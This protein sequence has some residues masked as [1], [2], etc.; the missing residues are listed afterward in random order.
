MEAVPGVERCVFAFDDAGESEESRYVVPV[1]SS[2]HLYA[3]AI[4]DV[5]DRA[6]FS[7]FETAIHNFANT[8]AMRLE[9]LEYQSRLEKRV[10]EQ[11]RA[12]EENRA[13]LESIF[14][15]TG[16]ATA[17]IDREYTVVRAN[18]EASKLLPPAEID[19]SAGAAGLVG[20]RCYALFYGR[21]EP[22]EECPFLAAAESD[23]V[24][25]WIVPYPRGK[26]P[27]RW[28]SVSA[29]PIFD[30]EGR[31]NHVIESARDITELKKLQE[32]LGT[33]LEEKELL[34]REIHHRV[35]NNLNLAVSIL[36]LQFGVFDDEQV[37]AALA[38]SVDRIQSMSLV[39]QFLYRSESQRSIAFQEFVEKL[40]EELSVNY[41]VDGNVTVEQEISDIDVDV[42]VAIS[43]GLMVNELI[44]NALKY[45]F[46][47]GE[48]GRITVTFREADDDSGEAIILAVGDD[49]VGMPEGFDISSSDSLGMQLIHGL[50]EQIQG[51]YEVVPTHPENSERPGTTI[52]ITFPGS[53]RALE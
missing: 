53:R 52:R 36:S 4:I 18:R 9:N 35:K 10:E 25:E 8:L 32:S 3:W 2:D 37:Q 39:H 49:G 21:S 47:E 30:E 41:V 28:F 13:F 40:V 17:V 45:A 26:E 20:S 11:T 31:V 15:S 50:T 33:A 6:L 19:G 38:A 5:A 51:R 46:P 27:E 44:T 29:F 24:R 23:G 43:L 22:C 42:N 7:R 48:G 14:E 34:L 12:L 1:Q 16:D